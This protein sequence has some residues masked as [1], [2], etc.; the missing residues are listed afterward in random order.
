MHKITIQ[1]FPNLDLGDKRR[2]ER[3]VT[4]INNVINQPGSSIPKQ[5]EG[6]YDTKATYEFFKNEEVSLEELQKAISNYGSDLVGDVNQILIAHDICEISYDG[7]KSEGLGYVSGGVNQ[8][9]ALYNSIAI[10]DTGIPIS[11]LYQQSYLRPWEQ[12]GKSKERKT[13]PFE[14]KQSYYWYQGIKAVN[15]LLGQNIHKIHIADREAD[16][17]D[18]FFLRYEPNTDLLFRA[19]QNRNIEGQ[20]K[21]WDKVKEQQAQGKLELEI[22]DATGKKKKG[23]EVELRYRNVE[24]LKPYTSKNKY[25]SVEMTAIEL[26]QVSPKQDWQEQTLQWKL[27]TTMEI[28]TVQQGMEC[29]KLYC[30]RWLIERFHYVLKSG[31]KIEELQLH[32]A[33]SLQKAIHVYSIAAMKIMQLVYQSRE[34]PNVSCEVVLTKELWSVLYILI[35]KTANLPQTPPTLGEAVKWIGRLGGHLGRKSDGPPGLKTVWLG[36][37][38]ICD[39][40]S[41]LSIIN[42]LNLGKA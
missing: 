12:L 3:F 31:T 30:Y 42:N 2:N 39:A 4:I 20:N 33:S 17:Y 25:E 7:L 23:I 37:Q 41:A 24:I 13:R 15:E 32:Q 6:W 19:V 10:S 40:A 35:H 26:T 11:L 14:E 22:P 34:T 9:I 5:N 1:N 8:G 21:I 18:L 28:N 16:I 36:Y 38:R 27:L 29:V